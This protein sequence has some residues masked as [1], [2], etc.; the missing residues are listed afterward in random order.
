MAFLKGVIKQMVSY[1]FLLSCV[2]IKVGLTDLT[3]FQY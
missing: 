2:I 1:M 3:P